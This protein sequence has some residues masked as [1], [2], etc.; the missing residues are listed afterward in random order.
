M[1]SS[2][3]QRF[4]QRGKRVKILLQ[5]LFLAFLI[6]ATVWILRRHSTER[7]QLSEGAIYGTTYRIQ[8]VYPEP[9]DSLI[10]LKLES[11]DHSLSMFNPQS[12]VSKINRNESMATDSLFREVYRLAFHVSEATGGAYD[13]TVAPLVNAWGFGTVPRTRVSSEKLDSLMDFVGFKKTR[14]VGE[15]LEKADPRIQLDFSSVAK[16]F[17]VDCVARLFD[18][19]DIHSYM[20]EIGGEVIVK[21][22]H[23]EDRPWVIGIT[24]PAEEESLAGQ[25]E[26]FQTLSITNTAMATSGNY[27]RFYEEGGKRFAHTIDPRSGYPVQHSL[28]SA[29]VFAPDCA[30]ADAFATAFMVL[31][32]DKSKKVLSEHKNLSAYLIYSTQAGQYKVWYTSDLKNYIQR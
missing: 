23:P 6:V 5:L 21:G 12:I 4:P 25:S 19:L 8:Y 14:L 16:G 30:T 9:L 15:K 3:P 32:L 10:R 1:E 22:L 7:L 24:K 11:V 28:L 27:R 29:T 2:S 20:I 13:V 17:G 18:S 31:G 26:I